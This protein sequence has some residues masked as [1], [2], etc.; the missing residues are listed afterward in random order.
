MSWVR[1]HFDLP[2][3]PDGTQMPQ[4]AQLVAT[5]AMAV[6]VAGFA[7]YAVGRSSARSMPMLRHRCDG[8]QRH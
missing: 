2:V 3:T 1:G 4:A 8:W 5:V 6:L 7:V